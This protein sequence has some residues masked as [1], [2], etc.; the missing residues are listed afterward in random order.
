MRVEQ[1]DGGSGWAILSHHCQVLAAKPLPPPPSTSVTASVKALAGGVEQNLAWCCRA[2]I[3]HGGRLIPAQKTSRVKSISVLC[4]S[5]SP[6]TIG[7]NDIAFVQY[8]VSI[9]QVTEKK[10]EKNFTR[11]YEFGNVIVL[12]GPQ[13][14][15]RLTSVVPRGCSRMTFQLNFP[16][17]PPTGSHLWVHL[18]CLHNYWVECHLKLVETFVFPKGGLFLAHNHHQFQFVQFCL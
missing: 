18:K 1:R 9:F 3:L 4:R 16:L 7:N 13:L 11:K 10:K 2:S 5:R 6:K 8:L 14:W 17:A 12:V 15:P